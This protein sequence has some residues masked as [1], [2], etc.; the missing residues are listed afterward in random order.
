MSRARDATTRDAPVGDAAT[1]TM[2]NDGEVHALRAENAALRAELAALLASSGGTSPSPADA[3]RHEGTTGAAPA[4][5]LPAH[6]RTWESIAAGDSL[7]GADLE[8]YARQVALPSFGAAKQAMLAD[9]RALIVGAAVSIPRRALPRRRG[10][11]S[12]ALADA[13]VV[14]LSNLH[15]QI[16]H[17]ESRRGA[18]K[19]VSGAAA[20]R[21][22]NARCRVSTHLEGVTPSN[23]LDLV[24][25]ADVVLDCTDNVATR[26]LLSDACAILGV[27]LVSAAAV[28]LE[29]QLSVFCRARCAWLRD[30]SP[31][32]DPSPHPPCYRCVF[33]TPPAAGDCTSCARG[34]VLGPVPG[35]MGTMQALE[36]I[37][38]MTGLGDVSA[39]RLLTYDAASTSRPFASVRLRAKNPNCD[40]CG[41][42]PKVTAKTLAGY[43][44]EAFAPGQRRVRGRVERPGA[45]PRPR[46]TIPEPFEFPPE[47]DD[48][49]AAYLRNVRDA[50]GDGAAPWGVD[51]DAA[52]RL[53][54]HE[55]VVG[56]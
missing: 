19:A 16:I 14:E 45:S 36:A 3:L 38:V 41:A 11:R 27:P 15:R 10:R 12:P 54:K 55:D 32:A 2:S 53:G 29:G 7:T 51:D 18:P 43:D 23:A 47:L 39:G 22:L 5:D 28:S 26:Y 48:A 35:V 6:L 8:R 9:A 42:D 21:A 30:A 1:R 49:A 52:R 44:Y 34:G 13:D 24:R 25:D 4:R 37:K 40:A 46:R 56:E 20:V 31:P 33:P 50:A 17:A